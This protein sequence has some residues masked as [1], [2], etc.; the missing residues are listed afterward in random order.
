MA[1]SSKFKLSKL[2]HSIQSVWRINSLNPLIC[3]SLLLS[4]ASSSVYAQ[5]TE[6]II[7]NEDG[8]GQ[9]SAQ[10]KN[11]QD[12]IRNPVLADLKSP[13]VQQT[14]EEKVA[15]TETPVVKQELTDSAVPVT[16][17][18]SS[19]NAYED[20]DSLQMLNEQIELMQQGTLPNELAKIDPNLIANL[21]DNAEQSVS[22]TETNEILETVKTAQNEAAQPII[23]QQ[24][25]I[26]R[27]EYPTIENDLAATSQVDAL[28]QQI[29]QDNVIVEIP[30]N[31]TDLENSSV[32]TATVSVT[33]TEEPGFF[34]RLYYK[35]RPSKLPFLPSQT[36]ISVQV[37]GD[38]PSQLR[39][40]IKARLS[41][42]TIEAFRDYNAALPQLRTMAVEAAQAMGYYDVEFVFPIRDANTP[43]NSLTVHIKNANDPVIIEKQNVEISGK[44]QNLA[45]FQILQVVPEQEEGDIFN[46]ADYETTKLRINEAGAEYGFFD[47]FWR[48]H[49][50]KIER[51]QNKAY[52]DLR[53]ETGERYQLGPVTFKMRSQ[54]EKLPLRPEVLQSLVPWK[55]PQAYNAWRVDLLSENLINSR[56]FNYSSVTQTKPDPVPR[57]VELPEDLN[58]LVET[59]K[60]TKAE[61]QQALGDQFQLKD[62]E[63]IANADTILDT[64]ENL[65]LQCNDQAQPDYSAYLAYKQQQNDTY[66]LNEDEQLSLAKA[67]I[68]R[69]R[70][71]PVEVVLIADRLNS[72]ETGLGFGTDT[73]FRVRSQYRRSIVND[74]GHSFE[75]NMEVSEIRQAIDGRYTIPYKHPLDD[76]ITLVGGYEREIRDRL[77]YGIELDIESAVA[78]LERSIKPRLGDWQHT[79]SARYRF[80]NLNLKGEGELN[81]E[82]IPPAFLI[83]ADS[84]QESLLI[85]YEASRTDSDDPINPTIGFKQTYRAEIGTEALLTETDM[86][87]LSAGWRVIYSLGEDK[88]HQIVGRTDLAHILTDNFDAVPYN[89]RFFAGGDQSVRGFDYK[90]L[91]DRTDGF[92]IG[93]QSLAVGSLEYN[94]QFKPGWRIALFGDVGNAYDSEFTTPTAY[95]AGLGVRWKSPVG[96]IRL[97]VAAGLSDDNMPIRLHFFIGPQ[98]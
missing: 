51:P 58:A 47:S 45:A 79:I 13:E 23:V 44:G 62:D 1:K 91:G 30:E 36:R 84:E 86:A 31:T 64:Y 76:V 20:Y 60:I 66:V 97:D 61:I 2:V 96:P 28:I 63:T 40:N 11:T 53:Y 89:L 59:G 68:R 48:L 94:Y 41:N 80:D 49:D 10:V 4:V 24:P 9:A 22:E 65:A 95:S 98:L 12:Q 85:G 82:D 39:N 37:T 75:A 57:T 38:G 17:I 69:E 87:I 71:I 70:L 54:D 78:G 88:Q 18:D 42:Y 77:G 5:T 29:E 21:A 56:Y 90:S 33:E 73:G 43:S 46:H 34:K 55:N 3:T 26:K 8:Q 52:V 72:L 74:R 35:V 27:Y 32:S 83:T 50:A 6:H 25:E 92:L 93:G 14:F 67:C 19:T 81:L 16:P 7:K 15:E